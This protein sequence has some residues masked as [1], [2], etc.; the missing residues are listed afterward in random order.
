MATLEGI[1]LLNS[2]TAALQIVNTKTG[3]KLENV[4]REFS[5][6]DIN[7]PI[8]S[9]EIMRRALEQVHK[10]QQL[11][12]DYAVK[13]V[14]LFG[15]E[16]LSQMKNAVYFADQV[17]STTGL[18]IQWLNGNQ[19]SFYRQ[20]ALRQAD[21]QQQLMQAGQN[22]FVLGMSST[23][24]DLGY[25]EHDRFAFSQHSAV[26]PVRLAQTLNAM[27]IGVAQE[28]AFAIELINSKLADFWHMLPPFK[29]VDSL[30]LLGADAAQQIFLPENQHR[31]TVSRA[32]IQVVTDDLSNLNDQAIMEKYA[33]ELNDVPFVLTEMLLLLNVMQA[34]NVSSLQ[35]SDLT[36]LDGLS[37]KDVHADD[38]I[39]TAARGIADR[40][41]VEK[42]HRELVLTYAHQLFDRL[43]KIHH[44]TAR[45]RLLL[46][47]AALVHDVGSFINSQKHY[48][49]SEEILTGIDLYGLATVEQRMIASIARYHSAETPDDAL[50]TVEDFS[51]AQRLRIAKLSAILRLADALDDGRRQ[52]ITQLT[53]SIGESQV[54]ITA[55]TSA[56]L[57]L[58][59]FVF[60]QKAS[61]FE[62]VFGMP[63]VLKRKGKRS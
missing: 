20:L 11:L 10:F 1:I 51:P 35:I 14:Q 61:F 2:S 6:S 58:E 56:D 39:I 63:I 48:Q 8:F 31:M 21:N 55:Q 59:I 25:F 60:T 46:G 30:I 38:D 57:Q 9:T 16:T 45:D 42:Q 41:M 28:T 4:T 13:T 40:Y 22:I 47:V 44:L 26:G 53:V 15:S 17:E 54:T 5:E 36:V 29:A 50:R 43:K 18:K 34:I 3:E 62:A 32:A 23:R 52:K 24:I 37:V 33:V 7:S 12:R 19:E 49:Y 27:S